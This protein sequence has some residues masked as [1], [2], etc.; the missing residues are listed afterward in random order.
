MYG[1]VL[2]VDDSKLQRM[3]LKEILKDSFQVIEAA[4]GQVTISDLLLASLEPELLRRRM[5]Y[6]LGDNR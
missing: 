5:H 4:G 6:H 1:T 2:I 3:I